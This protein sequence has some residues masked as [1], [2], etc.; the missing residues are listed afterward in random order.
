[1]SLSTTSER[2]DA[3]RFVLTEF[4]QPVAT[5]KLTDALLRQRWLIVMCTLLGGALAWLYVENATVR[6]ESTARVLVDHQD[7]GIVNP[8]SA[9]TPGDKVVSEEILANHMELLRS[10]RNVEN[11]LIRAELTEADSIVSELEKG[12]DSTDYVIDNLTLS[13]G[14]KGDSRAA[15][16]IELRFQHVDPQDAA[17]ILD[18]V[19]DEYMMFVEQQFS[20]SLAKANRLIIEAQQKIEK[21]LQQ[22]QQEYVASRKNA[23]VLFTGDGSS[24]VYVEQ[25]K[26]LAVQL[27]AVEIEE[28]TISGRL[29]KANEVAAEY[30]DVNRILPI[31]ALGVID[32]ESLQRLGVFAGM[33]ANSTKSADF[34]RNQPE[35]LE[36]ARTQYTHLLRLMSE[37][38]RLASDFGPAHPEVRKLQEEITLVEQFLED[39]QV[40]YDA[41]MDEPQLSSRQ[42][43][44]AYIGFL[45]S[46]QSSVQEQNREL[47]GRLTNAEKRARSLVDFELE[48]DVLRSR[49]D[50][51]QL[52]FEGLVEQL[53]KLNMARSIDGYIH[54]ILEEP[55][56]GIRIWPRRS[57]CA[58]AGLVLG[59]LGGL[60]LGLVN[61]QMSARFQTAKEIDEAVGLP[62]L[63]YV[64]RLPDGTIKGLVAEDAIQC[65]VFRL[66]R[67]ILLNDVRS[68]RLSSLTATSSSPSDGK[69]TILIN[70]AAS[71]A[72]LGMPV[73]IVEADMRR[74]TLRRRMGLSSEFGLSEVLK[75]DCSLEKAICSGGVSNLSVIHAGEPTPAPSELLE[76]ESFSALLKELRTQFVLTIIDVGPVLA[77]SDSL[78]VAKKVDGT[79]LIVRPSVDS[80]EQVVGAAEMLRAA[81]VNVL[82]LVVNTCGSSKHFQAGRYGFASAY[83]PAGVREKV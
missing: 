14:G 71:F 39:H 10:R 53:R 32:T 42:L 69:S 22:A 4:S 55:R 25:Y 48:H 15:R 23:P 51:N 3:S 2:P 46:E 40:E 65:E 11:A 9:A 63:G 76:S 59:L 67:T 12:Q 21:E 8:V 35:R 38:Q 75:G 81:D 50:R 60:F 43:L 66:L 62:V 68:G 44:D 52:L 72:G 34:Q 78:V 82:G 47:T 20:D 19:V 70:V 73:V 1:M 56:P 24:N 49:I 7:A 80:R 29:A 58:G 64:D 37:K 33:K 74:P 28:V 26:T 31:E 83:A 30:Q 17:R 54:E 45:K 16:T 27:A 57:V 18:S 36:E 41:E 77:V 5:I 6:Y 61:D 13:R 79:I